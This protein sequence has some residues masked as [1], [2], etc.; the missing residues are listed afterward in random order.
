MLAQM[1]QIRGSYPNIKRSIAEG[2]PCFT[3]FVIVM[4]Q[5]RRFRKQMYAGAEM[6]R[7]N[8]S[9]YSHTGMHMHRNTQKRYLR[10][11]LGNAAATSKAMMPAPG[12][13]LATKSKILASIL[14]M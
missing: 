12:R 10:E 1:K 2:S 7:F 14:T 5:K 3:P 11:R 8:K 6:C 9:R 13:R 4:L